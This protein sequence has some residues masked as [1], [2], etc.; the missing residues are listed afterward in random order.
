IGAAY[1]QTPR[2]SIRAFVQL[3]AILEQNPGADWRA[4]LGSVDVARE[5][6][7]DLEPLPGDEDA[8]APA[9]PTP[10]DSFPPPPPPPSAPAGSAPGDG[11]ALATFRL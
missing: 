2:T 10:S 6:N 5:S 8:A 4:L 9:P 3:L 11:D 7:P 1:F